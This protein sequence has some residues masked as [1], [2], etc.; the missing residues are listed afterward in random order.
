M[1]PSL[2]PYPNPFLR[3]GGKGVLPRAVIPA[4]VTGEGCPK[5][6]KGWFYPGLKSEVFF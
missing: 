6:R 2:P 1:Y 5:D 3:Y 4:P